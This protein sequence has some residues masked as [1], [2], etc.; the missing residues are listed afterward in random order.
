MES[1]DLS[2]GAWGK[3]IHVAVPPNNALRPGDGSKAVSTVLMCAWRIRFQ[4]QTLQGA[5]KEF[6]GHASTVCAT[7]S[8]QKHSNV[9]PP[10]KDKEIRFGS[11]VNAISK[12]KGQHNLLRATNRSFPWV[13]CAGPRGNVSPR[14]YDVQT[15]TLQQGILY[16]FV[17]AP[18]H[19]LISHRSRDEAP[20][21]LHRDDRCSLSPNMRIGGATTTFGSIQAGYLPVTNRPQSINRELH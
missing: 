16:L 14:P 8:S 12:P 17:N 3:R 9:V 6:C 1:G 18:T 21:S 19:A 2:V 15:S 5:D 10:S 7:H 13:C 4:L 20:V 11:V